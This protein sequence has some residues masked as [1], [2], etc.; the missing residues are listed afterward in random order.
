MLPGK[1]SADEYES[2]LLERLT[3]EFPPPLFRVE[4]TRNGRLHRRLGRSGESRQLD[5]AVYRGDELVFVA[6]AKAHDTRSLEIAHVDAFVGLL[7]DVAC[8]FGLLASPRGFSS[9]ARGRAE[10]AKIKLLLLTYDEALKAEFLPVARQIYPQDW[11]YHPQLAAAVLA[12]RHARGWEAICDELN[13]IPF[14]EWEQYVMYAMRKH[15]QEALDFLKAV[16]LN[17]HE[18]GWRYNAARILLEDGQMDERLRSI[19]IK[20]EAED[21]AFMKL[22]IP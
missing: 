21:A 8:R 5:V 3:W 17:H 2:A 22:L 16:A 15:S 6:D 20:Q 12:V 13:G 11:A 14:E 19:L 4:G 9:G 10:V 1:M 18:A 7:D